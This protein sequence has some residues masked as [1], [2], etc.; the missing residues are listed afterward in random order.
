M[1]SEP[2]RLEY[3]RAVTRSSIFKGETFK[4]LSEKVESMEDALQVAID[5]EKS[6]LHVYLGLK[7][8]LGEH[9]VIDA[10]IAEERN[11]IVRIFTML[12]KVRP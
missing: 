8:V 12:E 1:Q 5:F 4:N 6:T 2:E 7:E 10:V 3:L 11:H 9:E